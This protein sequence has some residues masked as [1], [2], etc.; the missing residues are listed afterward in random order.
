MM[1]PCSNV[2]VFC[3]LLKKYC[4]YVLLVSSVNVQWRHEM[5]TTKVA[6]PRWRK[7][8]STI[9][10]AAMAFFFS[11][12][13]MGDMTQD[14]SGGVQYRYTSDK[15]PVGYDNCAVETNPP[16]DWIGLPCSEP[17]DCVTG[18]LT[19]GMPSV[20]VNGQPV[21]LIYW[22]DM[23]AVPAAVF[24]ADG[25]GNHDGVGDGCAYQPDS[26]KR[27]ADGAP[28]AD[29]VGDVCDNCPGVPNT[30]QEDLD[31]D[32]QGDACDDE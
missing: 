24:C 17:G 5:M 7:A 6:F 12:C 30:N 21:R 22:P 32:G 19:N 9:A 13:V 28:M 23:D 1:F 18:E 11:G 3:L 31:G 20:L 29:G 25:D 15:I 4:T 8:A 26:D 10:M 2:F 14:D 16:N 27:S